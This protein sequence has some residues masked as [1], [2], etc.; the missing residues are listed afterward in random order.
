MRGLVKRETR[1]ARHR[2]FARLPA[3]RYAIGLAW[4]HSTVSDKRVLLIVGGGIAAYKCLELV[5]LLRENLQAF[6]K[7]SGLGDYRERLKTGRASLLRD[8]KF[9]LAGGKDF[10]G[11]PEI[12]GLPCPHQ[13]RGPIRQFRGARF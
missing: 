12:F 6:S 2:A 7:V 11:A 4:E 13:D 5:R 9:C 3:K 1:T 8:P 10:G